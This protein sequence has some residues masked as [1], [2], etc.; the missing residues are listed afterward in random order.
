[1]AANN[2][3]TVIY[4]KHTGLPADWRARIDAAAA[5]WTGL[6]PQ[7]QFAPAATDAERGRAN[8]QFNMIFKGPFN[9]V[10]PPIARTF[11]WAEPRQITTPSGINNP[12]TMLKFTDV[13]T[14]FNSDPS[15][16]WYT[17]ATCDS[18]PADAFDLESVMLH[19]FGHWLKLK[20]LTQF[21]HLAF[22]SHPTHLAVMG[23]GA[24]GIC[25]RRLD[26]AE[27]T[28]DRYGFQYLYQ[29]EFR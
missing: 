15:I 11:W 29:L 16:K 25:K 4:T 17:G 19:E 14:Q 13:D 8:D 28:D 7:F 12:S 3:I 21:V 5:T 9:V 1:V 6:P 23:P 26:T 18:I 2:D 27:T 10:K 22:G 20:D 24:P